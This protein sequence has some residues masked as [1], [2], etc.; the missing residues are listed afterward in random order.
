MPL[1]QI[2]TDKYLNK[3]DAIYT[4]TIEAVWFVRNVI[5]ACQTQELNPR[6]HAI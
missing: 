2:L 5:I 3:I 6:Y 4:L 1:L